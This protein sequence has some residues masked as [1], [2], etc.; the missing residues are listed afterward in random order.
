MVMPEKTK[1]GY[2][3]ETKDIKKCYGDGCKV[4][5]LNDINIHVERGSFVS[6]MGPSGSGK[7]TLLDVLGCLLKPTSGEVYIDGKK[8][9]EIGRAHV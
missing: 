1:P 9:I 4:T 7:T 6:I 3:I 5:A 2:V 8:V